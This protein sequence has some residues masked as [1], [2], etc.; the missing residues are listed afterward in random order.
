MS[1]INR[2]HNTIQGF[3]NSWGIARSKKPAKKGVMRPASKHAVNIITTKE[4]IYGSEVET[5]KLRISLNP[6]R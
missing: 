5:R 1:V 2:S 3:P 4:N 6:S